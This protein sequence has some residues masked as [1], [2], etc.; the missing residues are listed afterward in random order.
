[1]PPLAC[2]WRSDAA[3]AYVETLHLRGLS[4]EVSGDR[5]VIPPG[6]TPAEIE[7]VRLLK[8]EL[9]DLVSRGAA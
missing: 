1:M 2:S 6:H 5:L 4:L 8:P 7:L 3:L 9:M